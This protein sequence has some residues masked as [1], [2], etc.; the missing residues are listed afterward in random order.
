MTE[1]VQTPGAA[2]PAETRQPDPSAWVNPSAPSSEPSPLTASHPV[3]TALLT[4]PTAADLPNRVTT[5][6]VARRL[7]ELTAGPPAAFAL[8][9]AGPTPAVTLA[10]HCP[11][12]FAV[13]APADRRAAVVAD[14]AAVAARSGQ[15][16]LVLA[17]DPEAVFVALAADGR[18][19]GRAVGPDETTDGRSCAGH[20]ALARGRRFREAARVGLTDRVADLQARIHTAERREKLLAEADAL[21]ADLPRATEWATAHVEGTIE[22]NSLATA[23]DTALAAVAAHAAQVA[24]AEHELT[25]LQQ[26][27]AQPAGFFK[28]LFGG[29]KVEPAKVDAAEAK[30]RDLKATTPP[31]PH[32]AFA[33]SREKLV[34]DHA[35]ARRSSLEAKLADV[36]SELATLPPAEPLDELCR[37]FDDA[38]TDLTRLDAA[39]PALPAAEMDAVRLVVGPPSAVGHD[40]FVSSTHPEVEP[41][42]DRVLFADAEDLTDDTFAA[43]ARLGA[44]WVLVGTPDPLHAPGYRNGKP[45][46]V[47]FSGWWHRLHSAAWVWEDGR[48]LARLFAVE[49]RTDLSCEPLHGRPAVEVRWADRDGTPALAEVLFPADMTLSEAKAFLLNEADEARF[50]GFGPQ[51][52]DA[53]GDVLRCRWPAIDAAGGTRETADLGH[54]VTEHTASG[55]TTAVTFDVTSWTRD[56]AARWLSE[57]TLPAARTAVA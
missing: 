18:E 9:T 48:P 36:N 47:F 49:E 20:T 19:V 22:L 41:R 57:R 56:S 8:P 33:A 40:P 55:L 46:A 32:A 25:A 14:I 51:E 38:T 7:A 50:A 3:P 11:D 13:S 39:P 1:R 16:V 34:A 29:A 35:A 4:P 42:F 37:A 26:A 30:L 31:D 5:D 24:E 44:A 43:A 21:T 12:L 10:A 28:K 6:P 53:T 52:W 17:N 23:R 27:A 2:G 15:R 45:R 54:G